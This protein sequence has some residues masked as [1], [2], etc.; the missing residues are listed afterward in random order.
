MKKTIRFLLALTL[1]L[2]L[3]AV[4]HP[5]VHALTVGDKL[6]DEKLDQSIMLI[7]AAHMG[8]G[9]KS[10]L[11]V[12]EKEAESFHNDQLSVR[13]RN[14]DSETAPESPDQIDPNLE[15]EPFYEDS[16][17]L[18]IIA[19]KETYDSDE[20]VAL[21][22]SATNSSNFTLNNSDILIELPDDLDLVEGDLQLSNITIN[23]GTSY[24][25]T[26]QVKKK[27]LSPST[28][29]E[30]SDKQENPDE[31]SKLDNPTET[32]NSSNGGRNLEPTPSTSDSTNIWLFATLLVI[33]VMT[34]I[35]IIVKKNTGTAKKVTNLILVIMFV[36]G[37]IPLSVYA[38][39]IITITTQKSF[40][41]AGTNYLIQG[42][43]SFENPSS[44]ENEGA[45]EFYQNNSNVIQ[46]IEVEESEKVSTEAEAKRILNARG[47]ADLPITYYYDIKGQ[48]IE[49]KEIDAESSDKHPLYKTFMISENSG[50]WTI[51]LMNGE[52]IA[53]PA[54][55]NLES[56]L[57][58]QV[59]L[60]ENEWLISYD[61]ESNKYFVT[62][63]A[64]SAAFMKIIDRIDAETLNGM[65]IEEVGRR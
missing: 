51:Y 16:V 42:V 11:A 43:L 45:E 6:P 9:V 18:S 46:V 5:A 10:E 61:N 21:T 37:F 25:A 15:T 13:H 34:V 26:V 35:I 40:V 59:I 20:I 38:M 41:I 57:N 33:S 52:V 39:D 22:I 29:H 55:F 58:A 1:A 56:D 24:S 27:A 23:P 49:E 60:S 36:L 8:D 50:L 4:S 30:D 64:E 62:V 2:T 17:Q 7:D 3:A 28:N 53:Y 14:Y 19:D 54:S 47:F 65:T 44:M 31:S 48:L 32:E 63:P 12:I